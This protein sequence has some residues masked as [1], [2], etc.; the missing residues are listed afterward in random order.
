MSM[1]RL[2]I[3]FN[4][5]VVCRCADF[6][7]NEGER[8][9]VTFPS[10]Q[11]ERISEMTIVF[12][13]DYMQH[14]PQLNGALLAAGGYD[15]TPTLRYMDSLW[16]SADFVALNFETTVGDALYTG[17][18]TFKSP[19][20]C[21]SA[22]KE[23]GV[24]IIFTANNHCCDGGGRG[25]VRTIDCADS[26]GL[27]HLGTYKDSVGYANNRVVYI[28]KDDIR[29]ALLN[30][31][32]G[33]NGIPVPRGRVVN[34]I[35]TMVIKQDLELASEADVRVVSIHWGDE[36]QRMPNSNQR[37]L[38]ARL[39][40]WGA[41]VI[42]GTHPHVVQPAEIFRSDDGNAIDGVLFYSLGNFI[43]NQRDRYRDG[44][45]NVKLYIGKGGDGEIFLGV[46]SVPVWVYKYYDS[47]A[48]R[49]SVV[50][51]YMDGRVE[52][53]HWNQNIYKCSLRDNELHILN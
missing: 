23:C 14:S 42:V 29:V 4:L 15:F 44:G 50:P 20:E 34:M 47:G 13:G 1:L 41:D 9:R 18:P 17:Y 26:L 28:E 27:L 37:R 52:M 8:R 49:Y 16:S 48:Y 30:Y 31:T 19:V 6:Q 40:D 25:L 39:H 3:F 5:L 22:L 46:E 38:G 24:D 33:T 7:I 43:S 45:L 36:Y 35:D 21:M 10:S 32:Y 11:E 12:G 2:L 53:S 51:S